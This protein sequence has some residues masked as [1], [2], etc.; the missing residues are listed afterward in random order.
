MLLQI[1]TG[2]LQDVSL[3]QPNSHLLQKEQYTALLQRILPLAPPQLQFELISDKSEGG[4][5]RGRPL[6]RHEALAVEAFL[7]IH[8]IILIFFDFMFSPQFCVPPLKGEKIRF[9]P[10]YFLKRSNV[11]NFKSNYLKNYNSNSNSTKTYCDQDLIN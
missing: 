8:E 4:C 7:F 6:L 3:R 10:K 2:I 11:T 9:R 1:G 5:P